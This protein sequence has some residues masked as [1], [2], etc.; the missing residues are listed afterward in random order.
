M[1]FDGVHRCVVSSSQ[2]VV[3]YYQ[4]WMVTKWQQ[5]WRQLWKHLIAAGVAREDQIFL[6]GSEHQS[7]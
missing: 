3:V 2:I 1:Q 5:W 7:K 4:L 6:T